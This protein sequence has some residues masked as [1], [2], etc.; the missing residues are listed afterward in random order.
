NTYRELGKSEYFE[1]YGI[2]DTSI[3]QVDGPRNLALYQALYRAMEAGLV[4]SCHDC[5]D[6]GLGVALAETAMAGRLG[7]T[8]SLDNVPRDTAVIHPDEILFSESAGRFL[9]T[10]SRENIARFEQIMEGNTFARVGEVTRDQF[11]R[12]EESSRGLV[13]QIP[14]AEMLCAWKNP[15]AFSK[16]TQR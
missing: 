16:E 6:G 3:P 2:A 12:M 8:L 13:V 15:L 14:I 9:V 5:S 4:R 11:L 10:L 1:E 7:I